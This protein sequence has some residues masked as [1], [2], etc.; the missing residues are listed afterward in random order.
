[1]RF[2]STLAVVFFVGETYAT[3]RDFGI[4][5]SS[6]TVQVQ[7]FNV[8]NVTFVNGPDASLI[9]PVL[10]GRGSVPFPNYAFLVTHK[11]NTRI[12]WD[13]GLRADTANYAPSI[14]G[15][16]T[17]GIITVQP[18]AKG[19]TDLLTQGGVPLSSINQVIWSHAH[20][21]HVGDMSKFPS[22]TQLVIGSETNTATFP[23]TAGASLLASDFANRTVTK[24]DFSKA[25][26]TFGN[27]K[28]IDYFGDGSF[29]LV[30][31]PGHFPGHMSALARVTPTSFVYLGSDTYHNAAEMRPRPEFQKN[32]PCPA[33]LVAEAKTAISTDFFWSPKTTDGAFDVVSRADPLMVASD[34]PTSLTADPITA[35]ISLA[36]VAA[37]DADPDFFVVVAHDL[38]LRSSLPYFPKTL[39]SWQTSKLKQ[40]TVWNFVDQTNPAFLLSPL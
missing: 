19:M 22:T 36:K 34:L 15:L 3:Y 2:L 26:H 10:P 4:P 21:D 35:G 17:A 31:T 38:S 16:F 27:L 1:M 12:V 14:A 29:Y 7:A 20:F 11:N 9:G 8:V 13:L 24:I 25:N 28:A 40:N 33:H 39:N 18:G 30:D 37:F 23:Q 5:V 32:Y 6:A